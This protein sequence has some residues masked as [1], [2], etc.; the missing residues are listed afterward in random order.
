MWLKPGH[1]DLVILDQHYCPVVKEANDMLTMGSVSG[2]MC[3]WFLASLP[4]SVG[5][6]CSK[7]TCQAM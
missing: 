5:F 7:M 4:S 1:P 2:H 3:T 6:T